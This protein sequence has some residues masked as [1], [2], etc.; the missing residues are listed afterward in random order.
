MLRRK[1]VY[2]SKI[3]NEL[4]IG[5]PSVA[6]A[7]LGR[8]RSTKTTSTAHTARTTRTASTAKSSR[9]FKYFKKKL[10]AG[11]VV[12]GQRS[13]KAKSSFSAW[14]VR[15]AEETQKR[16]WSK[17]CPGPG[18]GQASAAHTSLPTVTSLPCVFLLLVALQHAPATLRRQGATMGLDN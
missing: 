9:G 4:C 15:T 8:S 16:I 1:D 5:N 14:G 3:S 7:C 2:K 11:N 17:S 6:S 10:N 12:R 18:P 13:R